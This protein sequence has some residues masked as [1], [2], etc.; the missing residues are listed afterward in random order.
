MTLGVSPNIDAYMKR[1]AERP[2]F[3]TAFGDQHALA[4]VGAVEAAAA[5]AG[6]GGKLFGMF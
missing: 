3:A 5:G 4:V 2:A 1:C 6:G